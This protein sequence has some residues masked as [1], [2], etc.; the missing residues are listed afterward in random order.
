[1]TQHPDYIQPRA[2]AEELT[3]KYGDKHFT[4]SLRRNVYVIYINVEVADK[5]FVCKSASCLKSLSKLG[6]QVRPSDVENAERCSAARDADEIYLRQLEDT[7]LAEK[8]LSRARV[9]KV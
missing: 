3:A 4:I 1:M 2:L 6:R 8:V 5:Q 9:S 7:K